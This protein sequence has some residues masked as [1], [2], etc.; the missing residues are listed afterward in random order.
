M[1]C[2]VRKGVSDRCAA[3]SWLAARTTSHARHSLHNK[4]NE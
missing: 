2:I 1:I 4:A 3:M